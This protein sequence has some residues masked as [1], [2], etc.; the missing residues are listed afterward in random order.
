MKFLTKS[1]HSAIL[2]DG[3]T[4]SKNTVK[5]QQL[6]D[7]LLD[8]Q[9]QFCAYTE[10]RITHSESVEIEHFDATKKWKDDYFNY[11]ATIR[12]AN[13]SKLKKENKYKYATFFQSLFFHDNIELNR[14]INYDVGQYDSTDPNDTEAQGLI[15]Y[16]SLNDEWLYS[17]RVNH[18]NL[19]R[20][21]FADANYTK[22]QQKA[23]LLRHHKML[24]FITAIEHEFDL[25]LSEVYL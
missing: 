17:E 21:T 7:R 9:R 20:E 11:Y 14:R 1:I 6:K 25:D 16:L 13:L 15:D 24:S 19:L 23:Y 4:Y 8:E 22:T 18:I 5:N 2:K 10:K 12:Q 3:I